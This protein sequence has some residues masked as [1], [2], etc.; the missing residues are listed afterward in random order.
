MEPTLYRDTP[1]LRRILNRHSKD[2]LITI[3]LGW[4]GKYT[5]T[6]PHAHEGDMS[7][8]EEAVNSACYIKRA[9][10][11]YLAMR[12][13]GVKKRVAD[14]ILGFDWSNGLTARQVADLDLAYYQEN[15]HLKTWRAL[16]L[17]SVDPE[18]SQTQLSPALIEKRLAFHI[19]P[20][21]NHHVQASRVKDMIWIRLSIHDGLAPNTLPPSQTVVYL[22]WFTNSEYLLSGVIKSEWK[23]FI[24]AAIMR[25]FR[26]SEI[27]EWPLSGRSP[28]SLA[29]LLLYKESQGAL[30]RYRLN[31]LDENPLSQLQ[32][33]K[34]KKL[35]DSQDD[36]A[37]GMNDIQ[38][39]DINRIVARN[40]IVAKDFGPNAQPN[41]GRVDLQFNL[42]FTKH[43]NAFRLGHLN[44]QPFPI[45]VTMEGPNVIDGL[46]NM[47]PLGLNKSGQ[48]LPLFL[49]E[50]HSMAT[51]DLT[52][53]VP[54]D[55]P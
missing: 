42:P 15:A 46:R 30:S 13:T 5:F 8:D 27:Q 35:Q 25:L 36:Y 23:E 4:I 6:R 11:A 7:T 16:K 54:E 44:Q 19:A 50:L 34:Q 37:Q 17:L 33:V 2:A 26:A 22:I 18:L 39:V 24:L 1:A 43:S 38:A 49:S 40:H 53:S 28:S 45:K 41:L 55:G 29:E 31:Q 3:A 21:F 12:E 20:Y 32:M 51:N 48:A 9:K 47:I 10:E 14:R 52:V